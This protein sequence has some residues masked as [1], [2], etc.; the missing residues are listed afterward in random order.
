MFTILAQDPVVRGPGGELVFA[1]VAVPL[2]TLSIGPTGYRLKVVDFN[3][4]TNRLYEAHNYATDADGRIVDPYAVPNTGG[5]RARRR[6]ENDVLADPKFHSQNTYAIVMRTLGR[7]EH[8]LGRRIGWGFDGHQL[9]VVPH[10]FVD[11]N[12]FY[13]RED[14]ALV[15]GYFTG[16][17]GE[18]VFT[19]LSH[20]IVVHEA[21]HAILDGLRA[22]FMNES[23]PDQAGFHEGFADVVALLSVFSL[24][25]IIALALTGTDS[26]PVRTTDGIRLI[27]GNRLSAQALADGILFSLG[28]QFGQQLDGLR[29]NA[30]RQS[31]KIKPSRRLLQTEAYNEPHSRGEVFAAAMLRSMLE[32]WLRRIK[33]LGTFGPGMYNLDAVIAEGAKVADQLLTM[34]I[35]ALDYCPPLDLEFGDY[36]AALLTVDSEV[37]PDDSRYGYRETIQ[38]TFA[39]YGIDPPSARTESDGCW[40]PFTAHDQTQYHKTN[41]DSMLRDCEEVFRFLWENR[42]LLNVDDQA[43]TQVISVRPSVRF[44]PDGFLLKETVCEYTMK[45]NIFGAEITAVCGIKRPAG[46]ETTTRLTVYGGGTLVFDPYGRIKYHIQRPLSDGAWQEKRIQYLLEQGLIGAQEPDV[47]PFAEV[48]RLRASAARNQDSAS[49]PEVNA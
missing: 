19:C 36:L 26:L 10:A 42:A 22:G 33:E 38:K 13:S 6:F 29:A 37:A 43:Y 44:G 15:F 3:A 45:A 17:D 18:R 49:K 5:V 40:K 39:S 21:T 48:H 20:D 28:K 27:D 1:R 34:A 31:L 41:F 32:L 24:K 12:A 7:F 35:R 47:N 9:H 8:A 14:R 30:L 16:V 11:A 2:E 46:I 23:G 4:S 25:E